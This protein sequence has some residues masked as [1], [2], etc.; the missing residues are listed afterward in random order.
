MVSEKYKNTL[1]V[2]EMFGRISGRYDF[3][4]RLITFNRDRAWRRSVVAM[5]ALPKGGRL[6]DLGAG[7]GD[8]A[9]EVLERDPGAKVIAAD[10]T[11][12]MMKVGQG[13]SGGRQVAWC[14]ADA[15]Q[16]PFKDASFDVVTSGFLVRNVPDVSAVFKEQMR[17]VRPGGRIVCLDT[18]PAPHNILRPLVMLQL[19]L[20]IPLLGYLIARHWSAYRYLPDSIQAFME[21]DALA[22]LMKTVGLR[23]VAYQRFMFGTIAVHWG[24]RPKESDK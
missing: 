3:M 16:L 14:Q 21:P 10:F 13:R 11:L 9:F 6:L 24:V 2:R 8:I 19:K 5:A 12:E 18:S 22:D 15:L 23:D 7:T 4:N 17:M 20:V 1:D